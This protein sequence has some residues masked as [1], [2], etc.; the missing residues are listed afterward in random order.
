MPGYRRPVVILSADYF[1]NSEIKTVT[2]A[3]ISSNLNLEHMPGNIELLPQNSGLSKKSFANLTQ[4]TTID[5][6]LLT[7]KVK[8]LSASK[9]G[10]IEYALQ[11]VLGLLYE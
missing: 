10:E 3:A 5:R 9:I 1:N 11:F 7:E 2:V 4:L 8:R 6:S